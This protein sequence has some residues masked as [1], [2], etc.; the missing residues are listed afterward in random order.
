MLT[1]RPISISSLPVVRKNSIRLFSSNVTNVTGRSS[2]VAVVS[3]FMLNVGD[4]KDVHSARQSCQGAT[5][6]GRIHAS[7]E[8][9]RSIMRQRSS[10]SKPAPSDNSPTRRPTS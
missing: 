3:F 6:N 7:Q 9:P 1:A 10:P 5:G 2:E 8:W 4:F